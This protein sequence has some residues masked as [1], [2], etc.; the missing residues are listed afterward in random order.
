MGVYIP[1]MEKPK[2]CDECPIL[3]AQIVGI[4]CDDKDGELKRV[5]ITECDTNKYHGHTLGEDY[6]MM[7][8]D[9]PLIEIDI[10][11]CGECKWGN[12]DN[13]G[14]LWCEHAIGGIM[15][16]TDFCSY[17]ERRND[18]NNTERD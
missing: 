15:K 4:Y 9:C 14:T 18:V 6:E 10:V 11:R 12:K 3:I 2:S 1:N 16:P 17:G 5:K 7:Y 8:K 13:E